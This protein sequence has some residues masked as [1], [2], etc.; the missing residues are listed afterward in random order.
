MTRLGTRTLSS[1]VPG[2]DGNKPP[3]ARIKCE[4]LLPNMARTAASRARPII[5]T[6]GYILSRLTDFDLRKLHRRALRSLEQPPRSL[7]WLLEPPRNRAASDRSEMGRRLCKTTT[8]AQQGSEEGYSATSEPASDPPYYI[9][10]V[11]NLAKSALSKREARNRRCSRTPWLAEANRRFCG[12]GY[13][14]AT[15]PYRYNSL[16]LQFP[17][18]QFPFHRQTL[19]E[20][21]LVRGGQEME[22]GFAGIERSPQ[23][24][25][26]ETTKLLLGVDT[27]VL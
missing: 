2:D 26:G 12:D 11:T 20:A 17:S 3:L 24:Q 15:I 1:Q 25:R 5:E 13:T 23:M 8:T 27:S 10:M 18:P 9:A 21:E 22:V 14:T 19:P 4:N 7:R 6:T 16:S